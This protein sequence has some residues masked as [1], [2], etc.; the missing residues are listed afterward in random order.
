M[1]LQTFISNNEVEHSEYL[2]E[3]EVLDIALEHMDI[4]AGKETKEYILKYGYLAYKYS[5]LYGIN[6]RQFLDSD[7]VQQTIY[8]HAHYPETRG[9]IALENQGEG[10][11]FLIDKE[12]YV[13][14]FDSELRCL[15]PTG[16]KLFEYI[17]QHFES[18]K[19]E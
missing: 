15:T 8:L 3:P 16:N 11:Y 7:M 6:A 4:Q 18:M 2:I 9:Y 13:Y 5:E 17:L 10:D 19:D 1:D 12:D 14:E